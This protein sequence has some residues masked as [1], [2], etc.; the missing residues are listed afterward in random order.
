MSLT[1]LPDRRTAG[2]PDPAE[3]VTATL[4]GVTFHAG[5]RTAAHLAWTDDR[6]REKGKRL[7][8]L[9]PCYHT[10]VAAS[11]GTH[12]GDGCVDVEVDGMSWEDGQSELR[13]LGW[14]AWF[15]P[16]TPGVWPSHIHMVSIGCPGPVGIYVPA[17][18]DDYYRHALGLKGQ[19]DSGDD[20]TWHPA[21]I[22]S[23]VFDY[24]AWTEE[25]PMNADDKQW[26]ENLID[27]KLAD[28]R[29]GIVNDLLSAAVNKAGDS[30]R[31]ALRLA[32]KLGG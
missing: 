6:L 27:A 30:V 18:V 14:V 25:Q 2:D 9:Q 19:H 1:Y 32:A 4:N 20:P 24:P 31:K 10:G 5:R 17:Q 12:D 26:L 16:Y 3:V 7:R 15:R 11:A 13:R 21:D 22:G 29:A 28:Q 23:T 8:I